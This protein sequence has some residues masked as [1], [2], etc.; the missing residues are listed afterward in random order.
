MATWQNIT[1]EYR[2]NTGVTEE[3]YLD[4]WEENQWKMWDHKSYS[5]FQDPNVQ[6]E[7]SELA[8]QN[9]TSER[10]EAGLYKK[11]FFDSII[12]TS[13]SG[14]Y[15]LI[16]S[17]DI[18]IGLRAIHR[19]LGSS[20]MVE[21]IHAIQPNYAKDTCVNLM[22]MYKT[23]PDGSATWIDQIYDLDSFKE[24]IEKIEDGYGGYCK[25]WMG[26]P[27]GKI[28]KQYLMHQLKA[29]WVMPGGATTEKINDNH[30]EMYYFGPFGWNEGGTI[31]EP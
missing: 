17:D 22:V 25:R 3:E 18:L 4:L 30:T 20:P 6:A 10:Y 11:D 21:E 26:V 28:Q 31:G 23:D 13:P 19:C 16:W 24:E 27:T 5:P 9:N 1:H 15:H 14:F 8:K 7:I 2:H 29:P 12:N